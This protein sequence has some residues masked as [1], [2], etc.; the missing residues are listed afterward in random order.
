M[1][2]YGRGSDW[3][4]RRY[5]KEETPRLPG[6][7]AAKF[8]V[9]KQL[10]LDVAVEKGEDA[11]SR[12]GRAA[13]AVILAA[14]KGNPAFRLTEAALVDALRPALAK[15][16]PKAARVNGRNVL[17]DALAKGCGYNG[18]ITRAAARTVGVA[19]KEIREI[20]PNVTPEELTRTAEAVLKKFDGAGPMAVSAHWH[21]HAASRR[22]KK[23]LAQAPAGWL[24]RLNEKFAD[25]VYAKGAAFEIEHE[26]DYEFW[27]LPASIREELS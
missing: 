25:S 6:N 20:E 14:R 23:T 15:E 2:R 1:R 13:F 10:K 27:R 24:G 3:W 19:L 12:V 5:R 26:T 4:C 7:A 16:L 9:V 18:D 17:F 21:S 22:A 8:T 11:A